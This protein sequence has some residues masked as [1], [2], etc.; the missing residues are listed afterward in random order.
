MAERG[1]GGR[2]WG[3]IRAASP[4]A[5]RLAAFLRR[6]VDER[7]LS[8]AA[9]SKEI[10]MSTSQISVYLGGSV[11]TPEAGAVHAVLG[12]L[13]RSGQGGYGD[14]LIESIA[15]TPPARQ[16]EIRRALPY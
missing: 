2:P 9:L 16:E 7:G 4:E 11:P 1:R 5:H 12:A 6:Q 10:H 3:A 8:L 14:Q 13:H 15:A